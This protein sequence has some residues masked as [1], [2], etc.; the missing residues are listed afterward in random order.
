VT[1]AERYR[2]DARRHVA[3][4]TGRDLA[5]VTE[6]EVDAEVAASKLYEGLLSQQLTH[7]EAARLAWPDA[8]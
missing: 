8:A 7:D 3:Q 5:D 1:S 2:A 6:A 4:R